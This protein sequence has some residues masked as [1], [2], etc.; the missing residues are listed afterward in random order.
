MV[1]KPK[2]APLAALLAFCLA[3][4][5]C[6]A[7]RTGSAATNDPGSAARQ[8]EQ[9]RTRLKTLQDSLEQ[10]RGQRDTEREALRDSE[11]Q[12]GHILRSL[13]QLDSQ[14]RIETER[15]SRSRAAQ[16]RERNQISG[17]LH[18]LENE[19]RAAYILGQQEYLKLLLSQQDPASVSRVLTYYQYLQKARAAH[20]AAA[21]SAL[22]R[23]AAIEDQINQRRR[24]L[25]TV[26]DD[27]AAKQRA[28]MRSQAERRTLLARLDRKVDSQSH[29]IQRLQQNE[30][31]LGQLVKGIQNVMVNVPAVPLP[32]LDSRFAD[33]RGRLPL[34]VQGK[35]LDRFGDPKHIGDLKWQGLFVAAPEG[36]NVISVFRGRVAYAD[37]LRGF[38]LLMIVDHGNGYMTLYGHNQSLYKEAGDW[39]EAG[40]VIASV[41]NT[42]GTP[43]PG[44]YFELRHNGVPRNPLHWCKMR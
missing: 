14:R 19:A 40:Q 24:A 33:Y 25:E 7:M 37:W 16:A 26:H 6:P 38:G 22:S 41:G 43:Q 28:L 39:V 11:R 32:G 36:R 30:Q 27:Q 15:L 5:L 35:I 20:I 29:E 3:L 21:R 13:K 4:I 44:L 9:L 18:K 17:Q 8:L 2:R 12:I 31:R 1:P 10:T 34:P 23:L 42:G